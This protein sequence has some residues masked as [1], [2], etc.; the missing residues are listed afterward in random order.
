MKKITNWLSRKHSN[1]AWLIGT[2]RQAVC[3]VIA[4]FYP[5]PIHSHYL[6]TPPF[7]LQTLWLPGLIGCRREQ[8][9]SS[10]LGL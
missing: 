5:S 3:N 10:S 7:L 6:V 1:P 8:V 4:P 2:E 9:V